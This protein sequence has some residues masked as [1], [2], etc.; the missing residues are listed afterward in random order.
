MN[1]LKDDALDQNSGRHQPVLIAPI[2]QNLYRSPVYKLIDA[3]FGAGGYTD[4]I[5]THLPEVCVL[6]IDRDPLTQTLS[7]QCIN[8][9][10]KRFV[11][12]QGRFSQMTSLAQ[13]TGWN[14]VDAIVLDLGVSSMQL[15]QPER[16]FSFRFDAPLDMRMESFGK[17]A[18]DLVNALPERLLAE[19]LYRY[20][21]EM[22]SRKI[23][24][25]IVK[26]RELT[27]ICTT[28][29]LC[30]LV[31][32]VLG[33]PVKTRIH[34]A[35][36]TFQALRM[37][38]NEE[39]QELIYGLYAAE[40]LLSEGGILS[41]V[42][43][44]SIEDLIVKRY[45]NHRAKTPPQ[46]NRHSP[47]MLKQQAEPLYAPT[48][49]ILTAKPTTPSEEERRINPRSRSGKLRVARRCNVTSQRPKP[50]LKELTPLSH[51][52]QI[53]DQL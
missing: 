35:T 49:T 1:T 11:F 47:A 10:P 40:D 32:T 38:V 28:A 48:Y 21:D 25:A 39:L 46:P 8:R 30:S 18:Y 44:H 36:R 20:G 22:H 53:W 23:A 15:D 26:R 12:R 41:I 42:T 45:L 13:S 14:T 33:T 9:Y 24:R 37:A 19:I 31:Q 29:E 7:H 17:S 34:P 4:A 43:F 27:P 16:G 5:L 3:T 2:L 51:L 50:Q 52:F 6:G